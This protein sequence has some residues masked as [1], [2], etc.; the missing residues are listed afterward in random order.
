MSLFMTSMAI[1][2]ISY[3]VLEEVASSWEATGSVV[4]PG[5]MSWWEGGLP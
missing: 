5:L 4:L 3:S 2:S 1:R